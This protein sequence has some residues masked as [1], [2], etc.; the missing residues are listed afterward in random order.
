[1]NDTVRAPQRQSGWRLPRAPRPAPAVLTA[2]ELEDWI[3]TWLSPRVGVHAVEIDRDKPF[4]DLGLDSMVAVR[5]SGDLEDLLGREVS[6]SVAWEYPT[7]ATVAAH[8]VEVAPA[9]A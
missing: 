1:M 9:R 4:T 3:A 7:I 2:A 5:M 8:L 6:P